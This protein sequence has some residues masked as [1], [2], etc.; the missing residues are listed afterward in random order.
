VPLL[1]ILAWALAS[2]TPAA[3]LDVSTLKLTPSTVIELDLG[4]LKG[5]LRQIGWSPDAGQLYIQTVE[6][7]PPREKPHHYL[8]A[9]EGG[10]VTIVERQP[11]WAQEYWAF[12]S[13]RTAPGV[14]SLEID[15]RR[16]RSTTKIGTGSDRP[17]TM[18]GSMASNAEN[19]AMA[20]E[21]Q[22]NAIVRFLLLDETISEFTNTRPIPGLMFSWGPRA[23]GAIAYTD[24]EGHLFL[25]DRDRHKLKIP[26]VKDAALPAWS[27]DGT[28]LAYA[29]KEGRKKSR[30]VWCTITH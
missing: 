4:Q 23:S 18:A 20:S 1:P 22:R 11:E 17:G 21:G 6:G 28:R 7:E 27:P 15:V 26:D 19:A 30:L 14:P 24:R 8:V 5:E 9:S 3:P 2:Q 16:E 13:D 25:L 10:P 29:V 12:K